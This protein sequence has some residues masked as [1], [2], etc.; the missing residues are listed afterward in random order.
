MPT[1]SDAAYNIRSWPQYAAAVQSAGGEAVQLPFQAAEAL[2]LAQGCHGFLLPGSPAD[3]E[4]A[5]YG[6]DRYPATAPAD[7][8]RERCDRAL[9]E[10]AAEVGTPVLGICFGLQSLN[11]WRGGT[12]VQDLQPVPVNHSAGAHVAVAHSVSVLAASLLG[13]LLTATEAPAEGQFRRLPV[14]SSHHQGVA[15]PGDDLAVVARSAEDGVIEALEG[16]IGQAAVV[17]VQWH[18]ERSTELSAA[19]RA[20]FSWLVCAAADLAE[21]SGEAAGVDT[22]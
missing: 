17:G 4:P 3:I 2:T 9:L 13:G 10:C 16:R 11:V 21:V 6:A 15:A 18:P 12:L 5:G 14:N 22:F 19:S 8:G 20:L 7:P 1:S